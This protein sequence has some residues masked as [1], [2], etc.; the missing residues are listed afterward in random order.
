[1]KNNLKDMLQRMQGTGG[2]EAGPSGT[3]GLTKTAVSVIP[4][5]DCTHTDKVF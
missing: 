1:M 2:H 4:S 3:S 5:H